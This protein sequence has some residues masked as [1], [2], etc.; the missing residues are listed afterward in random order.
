MGQIAEALQKQEK[1]KFPSHTEQAKEGNFVKKDRARDEAML[2]EEA[3]VRKVED[4]GSF[5]I[6]ISISNSGAFKGVLDLGASVSM[7]PLSTYEK[8]G[9]VGL[10]P[11][12]KKLM[13]AD[14]TS[15]TSYGEIR[16]VPIVI[17]GI[18][19][20]TDFV[21]LDIGDKSNDVRE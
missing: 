14:Q 20:L 7:M 10:K 3:Y 15:L 9:L 8:L 17:D 12:G 2:F 11:R 6:P 4:P 5:V 21:V 18:V 1:G 13:L 19:V 16:V